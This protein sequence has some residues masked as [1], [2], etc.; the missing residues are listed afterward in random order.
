M[1]LFNGSSVVILMI[2]YFLCNSPNVWF[3]FDLQN[4]HFSFIWLHHDEVTVW[5]KA[6]PTF[7]LFGALLFLLVN[8]LIWLLIFVKWHMSLSQG[9]KK[10]TQLHILS[11]G[12]ELNNRS[13][14]QCDNF[15]KKPYDWSLM[16]MCICYLL[17]DLWNEELLVKFVL[18]ATN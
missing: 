8:S 16:K 15:W 5:A 2:S 7:H 14:K 6:D 10:S 4:Y 9:D 18:Y 12:L 1:S 11:S 13:R 3:K 17:S